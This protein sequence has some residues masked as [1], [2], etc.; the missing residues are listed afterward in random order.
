MGPHGT[1][2]RQACARVGA[3]GRAYPHQDTIEQERADAAGKRL[4]AAGWH[5]PGSAG[6]LQRSD[7]HEQPHVALMLCTRP[8]HCGSASNR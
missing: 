6:Q 7:R 1:F 2:R 8:S 3:A 4:D 5:T